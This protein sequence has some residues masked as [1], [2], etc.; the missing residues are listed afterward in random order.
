MYELVVVIQYISMAL[1]VIGFVTSLVLL[2]T[3]DEEKAMA[4]FFSAM[5]AVVVHIGCTY[6]LMSPAAR[7]I[8]EPVIVFYV[9][10]T[11][12]SVV[13]FIRAYYFFKKK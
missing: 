8:F 4:V 7:S 10:I 5:A 3:G 9:A 2:R 6:I 12:V 1:F 13:L 11:A